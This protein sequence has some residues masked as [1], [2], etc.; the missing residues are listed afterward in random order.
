MCLVPEKYI[1]EDEKGKIS[2]SKNGI[3]ELIEKIRK[4][5]THGE[6]SNICNKEGLVMDYK[7]GS[8]LTNN[9]LLGRIL[10]TLPK[11]LFKRELTYDELKKMVK[12]Y[13]NVDV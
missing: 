4:E 13:L 10:Y 1:R 7:N 9:L 3:L 2:F 8:M 6:W 11:S 5:T 12:L